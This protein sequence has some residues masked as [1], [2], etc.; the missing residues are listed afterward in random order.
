MVVKGTVKELADKYNTDIMHMTGFLDGI[1]ASLVEENPID[2]MEEDT[3]VSLAFDKR[4][5]TRTW[6]MP[7]LIGYIH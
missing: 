2:T 4:D 6:L 5:C 3:V 7:R 1:N